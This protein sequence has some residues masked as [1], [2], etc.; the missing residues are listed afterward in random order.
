M[1]MDILVLI[2]CWIWILLV[3]LLS[4]GSLHTLYLALLLVVLF[5]L[6]MKSQ[7]RDFFGWKCLQ[8]TIEMKIELHLQW[9]HFRA[10]SLYHGNYF[11]Y[12]STFAAQK[13][14]GKVWSHAYFTMQPIALITI[15][16]Q[17][18]RIIFIML[19]LYNSVLCSLNQP[20][21]AE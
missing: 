3:L 6:L 20:N 11:S 14:F 12:S 18:K 2:L 21:A 19:W 9:K 8:S 5:L 10:V 4:F 17:A 16:S 7:S 1:T 13:L 15:H